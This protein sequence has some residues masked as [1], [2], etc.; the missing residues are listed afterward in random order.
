MIHQI[1]MV[2]II[3]GRV[4]IKFQF[5]PGYVNEYKSARPK[6]TIRN[7]TGGQRVSSGCALN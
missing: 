6:R 7:G 5:F 3:F 2:G 1:E 4:C